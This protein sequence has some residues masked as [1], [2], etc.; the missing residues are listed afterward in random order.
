MKTILSLGLSTFVFIFLL[1]AFPTPFVSC[2]KNVTKTDT[3]NKM[4]TL[5]KIDTVSRIDTVST[6]TAVTVQLLASRQW[7]LQYIRGVT[8]ND[9]VIYT[10]GGTY[11]IDFDPQTITFN[12]NFT[13]S[14][15]DIAS[16]SHSTTWSFSNSSN[17]GLTLVVSNK[18]PLPNQT[19]VWSNMSYRND[20]LLIDQYSTYLTVNSESEIIWVGVG[21]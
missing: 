6:D 10:R 12:P 19:Y 5:Q 15:T 18:F 21:Q 14:L 2:T 7:Q 11:N 3:V 17:T 9:S 4:D 8:D 20:S 1:F 13:G 16:A